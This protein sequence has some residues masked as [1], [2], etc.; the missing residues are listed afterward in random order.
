MPEY[1]QRRSVREKITKMKSVTT[2]GF[3]ALKID[4]AS[5]LTR[6]NMSITCVY[7]Q[8]LVE[9]VPLSEA[10]TTLFALIRLGPGVDV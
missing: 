7:F 1:K 3:S 4:Y 8:M 10:S 2:T 6:T 5:K 9:G